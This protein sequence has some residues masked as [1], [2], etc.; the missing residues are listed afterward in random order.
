MSFF[1][2][3]PPHQE[4]LLQCMCPTHIDL[5]AQRRQGPHGRILFWRVG[6]ELSPSFVPLDRDTKKTLNE[7]IPLPLVPFRPSLELISTNIV[8]Q[9]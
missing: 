3:T 7:S 2:D 4:M 8:S 1:V 6:E 5:D 9:F